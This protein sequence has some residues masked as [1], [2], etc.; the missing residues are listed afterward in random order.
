MGAINSVLRE[1]KGETLR[2]QRAIGRAVE[3]I[4]RKKLFVVW[5]AVGEI[6]EMVVIVSLV[7]MQ[8]GR[9]KQSIT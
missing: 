7:M 4:V 3:E 2:R 8:F 1:P 5:R 6:D 9:G